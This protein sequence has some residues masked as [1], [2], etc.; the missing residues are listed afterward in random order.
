MLQGRAVALYAA[1]GIL[2]ERDISKNA[3]FL[4]SEIV[5]MFEEIEAIALSLKP[6]PDSNWLE[7]CWAFGEKSGFHWDWK[8]YG[9]K[10]LF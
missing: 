8:H 6:E 9:S 4:E 3:H 7:E 1:A 5:A 2:L 10:E